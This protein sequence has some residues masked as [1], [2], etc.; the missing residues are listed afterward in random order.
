MS[1]SSQAPPVFPFDNSTVHHPDPLYARLRAEQ[2]VTRID[3]YGHDAWLVLGHEQ[4]RSVLADQ[5]FSLAEASKPHIPRLG[6]LS[7][8]PGAILALDPPEHTRVRKLA[9]KVFTPRRIEA[10]R[11][12]VREVVD[13][14]LADLVTTGPPVDLIE[15]FTAPLPIRMICEILG[16]PLSDQKDFER[17]TELIASVD[18][19]SPEQVWHGW[20][21]LQNYIA[22]LVAEKR[23]QPAEDLLSALVEARDVDDRLDENELVLFGL[24]LLVAGHETTKNQ[25]A[26]SVLVLLGKH[27]EQWRTL[28]HDPER[29]PTAVDELLRYI[30]LFNFDVTLPRVAVERVEVGG[31]TVSEGE[32]VLVALSAAN[33]DERE[34]DRPDELDVERRD[35]RHLA[36]GSGIH[37]CLGAQ[38]AKLELDV[39]LRGLV[40]ALP[41]LELAVA[42]DEVAWKTGSFVRAPRQLPVTW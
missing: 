39:G 10:L 3:F 37:R 5:R 31:V 25:L 9:T 1:A 30:S 22:G 26:N 13:E 7:V 23:R 40:G 42:E 15:R 11:P 21:S 24:M 35:N 4:A 2:P 18:G 33:R 20:E 28:V 19:V 17:W 6:T 36:F 41:G 16:V 29:V 12:R 32:V 27:P 34:F 38:L 8:P 14:L